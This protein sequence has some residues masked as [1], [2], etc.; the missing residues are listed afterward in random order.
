MSWIA[1]DNEKGLFI[2][3]CRCGWRGESDLEAVEHRSSQGHT[4]DI[5]KKSKQV[6]KEERKKPAKAQVPRPH[7]SGQAEPKNEP[8]Q[9]EELEATAEPDL[10][11][12]AAKAPVTEPELEQA[13]ETEEE[14]HGTVEAFANGCRCR[15]CRQAM[16]KQ[17]KAWRA[18]LK[19]QRG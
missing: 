4:I 15:E 16:I 10:E 8:A 7:A 2:Y 19:K 6:P 3:K 1:T 13:I 9:T 17:S 14:V 12:E 11:P 5:I 18:E